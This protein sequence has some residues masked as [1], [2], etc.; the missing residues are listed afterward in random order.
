[1]SYQYQRHDW[2]PCAEARGERMR[3]KVIIVGGGPVGLTTALE[4][5]AYG[6][7]SVVLEDGDTVSEGS[8]GLCWSKR[9]LEIFDRHGVAERIRAKGYTWHTGRLFHGDDEIYHFDLQA[10]AGE[11]FPA[12]VNLQQYHT[13]QFLVDAVAAQ[14][15]ID[16]RWQS[17]VTDQAGKTIA[18]FRGNS[19]RLQGTVVPEPPAAG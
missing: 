4:L 10:V 1:M 12:F 3:H 11:K 19:Y 7:P 5:A 18:L 16:H 13:E 14:P 17:K 6:V 9:T 8:R 2:R 15:L